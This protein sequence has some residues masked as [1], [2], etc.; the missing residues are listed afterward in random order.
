LAGVA[1]VVA[2]SM[3]TVAFDG[4]S[5]TPVLESPKGSGCRHRPLPRRP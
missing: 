2:V 3:K 4:D 1:G 5:T